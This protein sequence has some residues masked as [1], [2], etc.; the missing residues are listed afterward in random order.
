MSGRP[1][2]LKGTRKEYLEQIMAFLSDVTY[3]NILW[4]TGAAGAGKSTIA[5]TAYDKCG[6]RGCPPAY[7]FFEREKGD[8]NSVIRTVAYTLAS[9]HPLTIGQHILEVL[10]QNKSICNADPNDQ[11]QKLLLEPLR[12]ASAD[13]VGPIVIILDA[14]DECGSA[15]Q[16][17]DLLRL[18]TVNFIELPRNVRILVTSRP[19][20]DIME[21]LLRTDRIRRIGLKHDSNESK[22]DVDFYIHQE[23]QK[24]LNVTE[25]EGNGWNEKL[26]FLCNAADGLFIW[27]STAIKMLDGPV[28]MRERKLQRLV[29]DVGSVGGGIDTLYG[30]AL[31]ES[32]I[33]KD[34]DLR[35][36]GTAIL[37]F[38][39]VSK[40]T[41][42]GPG[43]AGLLE[44]EEDTADAVLSQ[45]RSLVLY[46][47]GQSVRLHHASFA[48]YLLST[49]RSGGKPWHISEAK[50]KWIV[51]ERCFDIMA[52]KLRFNICNIESSFRLNSEVPGLEGRIA[53][54]VPSHLN[55]ACRFWSVHMCE[56]EKRDNLDRVRDKLRL[57]MKE[58]LLYW[59]EVLSLTKCFTRIAGRALNDASLWIEVGNFPQPIALHTHV[60]ISNLTRRYHHTCILQ[61]D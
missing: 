51:T 22:R 41:V 45:L 2:C 35:D 21:E 26:Q 3:P 24:A 54:E 20:G 9:D 50:A 43:I 10:G 32:G 12:A 8:P 44:L 53:N 38:I 46:E 49:E 28:K 14:L 4:L 34:R 39:L 31:E 17:R 15:E 40:E 25:L 29:D 55:Y 19:E 61:L 36:A 16:R 6:A 59:L 56:L 23:I 52:E 5:V 60:V 33:W 18:L 58:K 37:R 1:R 7:I 11:F 13:V 47:P 57:F 30:T 48:D 27:A 42:S